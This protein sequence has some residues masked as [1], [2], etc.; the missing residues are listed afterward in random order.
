M[1]IYQNALTYIHSCYSEFVIQQ[2]LTLY[3]VQL[4]SFMARNLWNSWIPQFFFMNVDLFSCIQTRF[5][6]V[7]HFYW[8]V[9][10][11]CF[12]STRLTI[13]CARSILTVLQ[14]TNLCTISVIGSELKMK[15][16]PIGQ[17]L[18]TQRESSLTAVPPKLSRDT[19]ILRLQCS[20]WELMTSPKHQRYLTT[21]LRRF[22]SEGLRGSQSTWMTIICYTCQTLLYTLP[23]YVATWLH[24][25]FLLRETI[26]NNSFKCDSQQ[27]LSKSQI[28]IF[29]ICSY[30]CVYIILYKISERGLL[31]QFSHCLMIYINV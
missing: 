29:S 9:V 30:I 2:Q 16:A 17:S 3:A 6:Q 8:N 22:T 31:C 23:C 27:I 7:N 19:K 11:C 24:C 4:D 12:R 18:V 26:K 20:P 25:Q 5:I 15:S 1:Q 28:K 10:N 13:L 14:S 21:S